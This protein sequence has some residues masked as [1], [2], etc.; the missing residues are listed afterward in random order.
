MRSEILGLAAGAMAV[1]A[2]TAAGPAGA[3]CSR[4]GACT[5][6]AGQTDE[7]MF[8][9]M[10]LR[11]SL[12]YA[13]GSRPDVSIEGW[14]VDGLKRNGTVA[15]SVAVGGWIAPDWRI[16]L[17]ASPMF[18]SRIEYTAPAATVN[19]AVY[20]G[21]IRNTSTIVPVTFDVYRDIDTK[22]PFRPYVGAGIGAAFAWSDLTATLQGGG[23]KV[24]YQ[25]AKASSTSFAA[26]AMAG[27]SYDLSRNLSLDLGYRYLYVDRIKTTKD[28]GGYTLTAMSKQ[29]SFNQFMLGARYRLD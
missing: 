29:N 28:I 11:G 20:S 6:P 13:I 17:S 5:M 26:A 12:G 10:Y 18:G 1:L 2:V 3:A 15:T 22:T 25:V 21:S 24:E 8:D 19:G 7:A 27:I 16:E 9:G 4:P 23:T 14:S